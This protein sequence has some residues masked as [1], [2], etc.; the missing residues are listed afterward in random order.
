M[1]NSDVVVKVMPKSDWTA[2]VASGAY[3]GSADDRRD[4]FIHLSTPEQLDGTLAK[5]FKGQGDLVAVC[6]QTAELGA[7]LRWEI[8]RGGQQFPHLYGELPTGIALS[9]H[10]ITTGEDGV[11]K[12][13]EV[14]AGGRAG[15]LEKDR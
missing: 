4:G 8:S 3:K 2:A 9:V 10:D 1:S 11:P 7:D 13:P 5:H 15:G 6:Y 12:A 14:L